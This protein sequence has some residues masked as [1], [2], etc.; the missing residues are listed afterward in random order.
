MC[1]LKS[2]DDPLTVSP[3]KHMIYFQD[4]SQTTLLIEL[5]TYFRWE[6]RVIQAHQTV[7]EVRSA[8]MSFQVVLVLPPNY[9]TILATDK[10]PQVKIVECLIDAQKS[11]SLAHSAA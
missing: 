10:P 4:T 5:T 6:D 2:Q 9:S 1:P 3:D 11:L 8:A 7:F